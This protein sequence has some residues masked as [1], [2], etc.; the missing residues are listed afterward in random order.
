MIKNKFKDDAS[1]PGAPS[2][3][4]AGRGFGQISLISVL[5]S[6]PSAF[7][8]TCKEVTSNTQ[9]YQVALC[10]ISY[11][12]QVLQRAVSFLACIPSSSHCRSKNISVHK[13]SKM[14]YRALNTNDTFKMKPVRLEG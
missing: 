3:E 10:L 9:W 14:H 7:G 13:Q 1:P 11:D 5:V 4:P 2:G 6:P 12:S 8:V